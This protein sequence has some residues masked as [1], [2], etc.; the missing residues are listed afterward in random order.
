MDAVA[1]TG[2]H[3][4]E[5]RESVD[6]HY[7]T[8]GEVFKRGDPDGSGCF[9]GW[10]KLRDGT[11]PDLLSLLLFADCMAPPVFTVFGALHWVPTLELSVQLRAAP[12]SGPVQTRFRMARYMSDGIVEEDG[13][14]W[15]SS[16]RLV[17]LSRQTA[18]V[19]VRS[20]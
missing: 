8:G 4:I 16:G 11:D 17:A 10:L 18:K 20:R 2:V 12:A 15:D 6:Q 13:E 7:V 5:L 1:A 19:Q 14:I 3:G 9:N